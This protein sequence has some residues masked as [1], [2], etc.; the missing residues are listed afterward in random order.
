MPSVSTSLTR[1]AVLICIALTAISAASDPA[2]GQ[3]RV[4]VFGAASTRDALDAAIEAFP[5]PS[6]R[7]ISGVYAASSTLA[8]QILNG[9]PAALFLSANTI[10]M[11]QIDAAGLVHR[12]VDIAQNSLVL[13]GP[14][15]A[16]PAAP[17]NSATDLVRALGDD[18]LSVADIDAVP[19]GIYARQA[20]TA[21]GVWDKLST[22]LARGANVRAALML[23]ERGETRL[24]MVYRTDLLASRKVA[25]VWPI[26]PSTHD[27][28][29]YPLAV[30]KPAAND[31][32]VATLFRFL[33]SAD[34]Q[35][36]FAARGFITDT[37]Q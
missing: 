25:A 34:G 20:M 9:A 8:R 12:R 10:W 3:D 16:L 17:V 30:L 22:R 37:T 21:L 2:I 15:F 31:P 27:P 35:Q 13:I 32:I 36:I 28:I 19:A 14:K 29:V 5:N 7:T 11:D 26:P 33:N 23:V 1:L 6:G 24:G 18:R 4:L